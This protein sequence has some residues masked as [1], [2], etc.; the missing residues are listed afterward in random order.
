MT[1]RK[2]L[3]CLWVQ[4]LA[5]GVLHTHEG[6]KSFARRTTS[7]PLS[8]DLPSTPFCRNEQTWRIIVTANAHYEQDFLNWWRFCTNSGFC[9]AEIDPCEPVHVI[10]YAEDEAMYS[11]YHNSTKISVKKAWTIN[12]TFTDVELTGS[13]RFEYD[14]TK[15]FGHMMGRRPTILMHELDEISDLNT[16]V[17]FMDLDT[18]IVKDPRPYMQGGYDFW[19]TPSMSVKGRYNAGVL[20]MRP[21]NLTRNVITR[22]RNDL[23]KNRPNSNQLTFY[24]VVKQTPSLKHK[25]LNS[26]EFPVGRILK[27]KANISPASLGPDVV[28]FHNNFCQ[29]GCSKPERAKQLGLWNPVDRKDLLS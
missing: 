25:L 16:K 1:K 14:D 6:M 11:A 15:G 26:T 18:M 29:R 28:I 24:K 5:I 12:S 8:L 2:I 10:L 4:L 23:E 21:T 13:Q 22:W 27:Y 9:Q 7:M 19:F 17:F 3:L 20:V